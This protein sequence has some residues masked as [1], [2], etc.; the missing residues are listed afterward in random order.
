MF[1]IITNPAVYLGADFTTHKRKDAAYFV[2]RNIDIEVWK[3]ARKARRLALATETLKLSVKA[4]P[5]R[6]LSPDCKLRPMTMIESASKM[7]T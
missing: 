2:G 1:P 5:D 3:R 4:I 7:V 6:H